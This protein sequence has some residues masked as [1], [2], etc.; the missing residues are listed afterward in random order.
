MDV[1]SFKA[2]A[3]VLRIATEAIKNGMISV[4]LLAGGIW[5]LLQ[6]LTVRHDQ[7]VKEQSVLSMDLDIRQTSLPGRPE[8]CLSIVVQV[9]NQ[10]SR[11]SYLQFGGH[12]HL[13]VTAM[14][15]AADGTLHSGE[16]VAR[17]LKR[18]DG[19][20]VD[21]STVLAG[22]HVNLPFFVTV[23]AP[24]LYIVRFRVDPNPEQRKIISRAGG[25]DKTTSIVLS[26][27]QYFVVLP[28]EDR[29]T[30]ANADPLQGA[31]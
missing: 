18:P 28:N 12:N 10:G 24:G 27:N 30:E 6:F 15:I 14:G 2:I 13:T 7:R 1:E 22:S 5:A 23:P 4:G 17:F 3:E 9:R 31:I 29:Q 21:T 8:L 16:S 20:P 25:V 11:N 26:A 19:T